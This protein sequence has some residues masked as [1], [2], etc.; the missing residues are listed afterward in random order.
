M[1][2][3]KLT[4]AITTEVDRVLAMSWNRYGYPE[5]WVNRLRLLAH[6]CIQAGDYET[7][8]RIVDEWRSRYTRYVERGGKGRFRELLI[9]LTVADRQEARDRY[10]AHRE[11]ADDL[12]FD[13]LT[14]ACPFCR[15]AV[16]VPCR[17]MTDDYHDERYN[18]PDAVDPLNGLADYM[19]LRH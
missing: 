14:R 12:L 4:E 11:A 9:P 18:A 16:G 8:A 5:Y 2:H 15:A 3:D 10:A 1:D 13:P 6:L 17:L 19:A 7:P